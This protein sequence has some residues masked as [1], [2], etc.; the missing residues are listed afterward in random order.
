MRRFFAGNPA[1]FS[2]P[3]PHGFSGRAWMDQPP[4]EYQP[5][6]PLEPPSWLA[7]DTA[8]LG[9]GF[10]G[11]SAGSG[12]DPLALAEPRPSQ[13]EPLPSFLP[14]EKIRAVSVFRLEGGLA[15][16]LRSAPPLLPAWPSAQLLSRSVVQ[17][18]V[19]PAGDVIAAYLFATQSG[20][21]QA[22]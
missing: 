1:V 21:K 3:G 22:A 2:R 14:A 10:A 13:S 15:E 17:I 9:A 8:R 7:L 16:R 12:P 19:N 20:Q 6:T 4:E 11:L 5:P 18:A